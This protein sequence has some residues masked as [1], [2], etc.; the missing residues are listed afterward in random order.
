MKKTLIAM[1]AAV[2][3]ISFQP[4][5]ADAFW[6]RCRGPAYAPAYSYAPAYAA[7]VAQ[8]PAAAGTTAAAP[9]TGYRTYS[10]QPAAPAAVPV[11]PSYRA[12]SRF[13]SSGA[14]DA[15]FKVRGQF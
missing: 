11:A 12:P 15:G 9:A 6:G 1:A 14:H 7:P 8:T 13:P 10:Y 3:A 2:A 4:S 5:A